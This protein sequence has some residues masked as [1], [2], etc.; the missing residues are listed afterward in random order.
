MDETVQ[1]CRRL[2]LVTGEAG[3]G[4]TRLAAEFSRIA[5][6]SGFNSFRCVWREKSS[7]PEYYALLQLLNAIGKKS[8]GYDNK[9]PAASEAYDLSS[10]TYDSSL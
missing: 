2:L 9:Y 3:S 4:K 7:L 6:D 10:A 1:G 5:S 8:S